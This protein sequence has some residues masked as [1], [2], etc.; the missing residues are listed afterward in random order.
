MRRLGSLL[1]L[2]ALGG[3]LGGCDLLPNW[4]GSQSK[5][6][7]PGKRISVLS[8]STK[9]SADPKLDHTP[10]RL[11]APYVN[12]DWPEPGGYPTHAMYH[13]ALGDMLHE[14]WRTNIG[15]GKS[16]DERLPGAPVVDHGRLF[17]MDAESNVTALD[18]NSGRRLWRVGLTPEDQAEG[19]LGGGVAVSGG[20][21]FVSTGYGDVFALDPATGRK[22]WKKH[23]EIP[24]RG[25]PTVA[26]GRV[27][28]ITQDN[29]LLALKASDGSEI[30]N[31]T[32]ISEQA[33]ILT[34]ASP[35]VA[36]D[37]VVAPFSSGELVGLRTDTGRVLWDDQ[38]VSSSR[39]SALNTI[40]DIDGRPVI[41]RDR[42]FAI[43]N[44]GHMVSVDLLSGQRVW[45]RDILGMQQPWAAGDFL[46]VVTEDQEVVCLARSDGRV[47]WVH[48]LPRWADPEDK[49]EPIIWHGPVLASN[50]LILVSDHGEAVSLSPYDGRLLGK[51]EIPGGASVDPVVANR[52]LYILTNDADV[53]ALR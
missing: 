6:P 42:V 12:A 43:G 15:D 37:I 48:A 45:E 17:A 34:P 41:D 20:R 24:L 1:I 11:P 52:T 26:D 5:P 19:A 21:V 18:A 46:Y 53:V 31:Y 28:V 3:L 38:L 32:A 13:L 23:V 14:V 29:R 30:W 7:L 49:D 16:S 8:Y 25:G 39:V 27:Y 35:A 44:S 50:R 40:D 2:L 4:F 10:V 47:R 36:G 51:M 33:S 9:V 22:I